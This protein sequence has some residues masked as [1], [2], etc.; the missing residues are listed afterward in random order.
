MRVVTDS[1]EVIALGTTETAP[2]I[3]IID[4]SR[5]VT[6]D[7]G[8]TT[9]VERGFARRM[10]VRMAVVFDDV[11][12]VQARLAD[13]RATPALW[14]ADDRYASL[15]VRGFYKD[16][17]LDLAVP[18]L[19]YCTLTVEGLTMP[20]PVADDGGDPGPDGMPSTLQLLQPIT[21]TD[22][23]L[24]ASSAADD[25]P[26]WLPGSIY[27][28]GSRVSRATTHRV[29][30]STI[31]DNGALDPAASPGAWIDV[32]ATNRWAMFDQALGSATTAAGALT[33]TLD[34]GL[35]TA[36]ALLDVIAATVRVEGP[37]YDSM[38]AVASGAVT[39]LDLPGVF[40][41]VTI[42]ITGVGTVSVGTLLIGNIVALGLTEAAPNAGI[43][44][45]S[46]KAVDDFGEVTVVQRAWAKRM[47]ARALIRSDALDVVA[48]RIAEVR[49][50]PCLWIG[51]AGIDS[52]TIYGFFK[53]FSIEVG[54]AV[55]KLSL[56]IEGLSTAAPPAP[57]TIPWP[58]ITDPDG[59]RPD[60]NA[61]E[62]APPGTNV[63]GVPAEEVIQD[64]IDANV[65]QLIALGNTEIARIRDRA[66]NFPGMD[67]A[68]L[69]TLHVRGETARADADTV[70]REIFDLLG[71]VSEDGE[72]FVL[73]ASTV[74]ITP[75]ES[76][77]QRFDSVTAQ[78][79]D[80]SASIET[81]NQ[82][83]ANEDGGVARALLRVDVDGRVIGFAAYNDGYTSSFTVTADKFLLVDPDTG[84]VYF[85]AD[86]TGV[87]MRNV[88]VDTI[89]AGAIDSPQLAA[90]AVQHISFQRTMTDIVIPYVA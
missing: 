82:V 43:T 44:D 47:T 78:F 53:D 17:A 8:V 71:A 33:V 29:Y 76:L 67:G 87:Y 18:P 2:T 48:S 35:A 90:S 13:L 52:L 68:S 4:Y 42:T 89:K 16:F 79:G 37:G 12:A 20:A 14:I 21:V 6:D 11:D 84:F 51:Q 63:G 30:E 24:V 39:F 64:Q 61:T 49:A 31:A 19:S 41:Q 83:L 77:A 5:R 85:E 58:D 55:S 28:I 25:V 65:A 72:A 74:R 36:V 9:V 66:L 88:E 54:D 26:E 38:V 86:E 27:G 15:S 81:I 3:G 73:E 80:T 70:F 23:V 60:D 1:G 32:G 10:S 22:S 7:F 69:F 45:F 50:R 57:L 75:T 62:G 46:R 34:A 40:G 56:S 59:T